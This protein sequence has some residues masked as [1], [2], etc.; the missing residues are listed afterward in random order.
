MFAVKQSAVSV[1]GIF[2]S[3]IVNAYKAVRLK[4]GNNDILYLLIT[5]L[6][7]SGHFQWSLFERG[8]NRNYKYKLS[9]T[10]F[11]LFFKL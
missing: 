5:L 8:S 1:G 7:V 4:R 2:R 3:V 9:Y 6:I 11:T 10:L